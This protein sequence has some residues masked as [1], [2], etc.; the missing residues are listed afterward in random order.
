MKEAKA[1]SST[2]RLVASKDPGA[3][4]SMNSS[5]RPNTSPSCTL[6]LLSASQRNT[7]SQIRASDCWLCGFMVEINRSKRCGWKKR[8]MLVKTAL[9]RYLLIEKT[10]YCIS[11]NLQGTVQELKATVIFFSGLNVFSLLAK[12]CIKSYC[13]ACI[14]GIRSFKPVSTFSQILWWYTKIFCSY[15]RKKVCVSN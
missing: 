5:R 2:S 14:F 6:P 3:R 4:G 11:G 13:I 9:V 12:N 7:A 10:D 8:N 1:W 15:T